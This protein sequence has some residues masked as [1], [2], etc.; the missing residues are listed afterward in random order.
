PL[1][2][3]GVAPVHELP[4]VFAAVL[5]PDF[6]HQCRLR[7]GEVLAGGYPLQLHIMIAPVADALLPSLVGL[8]EEPASI[9]EVQ[10]LARHRTV[11]HREIVTPRHGHTTPVEREAV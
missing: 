6:I 2:A 5:A 9:D 3:V 10:Q 4:L 8:A 1:L 7:I 11:A